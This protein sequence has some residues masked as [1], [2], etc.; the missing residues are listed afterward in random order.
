MA[1]EEHPMLPVGGLS[2]HG[3]V[4]QI[5]NVQANP[6]RFSLWIALSGVLGIT[7]RIADSRD[8]IVGCAGSTAGFEASAIS[9]CL[10]YQELP[11]W[12]IWSRC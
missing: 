12:N 10:D 5:L 1:Q 6:L 4:L 11:H 8:G 3:S 7:A 2:L 9:F